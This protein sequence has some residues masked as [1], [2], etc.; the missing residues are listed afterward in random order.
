MLLGAGGLYFAG[1]IDSDGLSAAHIADPQAYDLVVDA[2]TGGQVTPHRT[3]AQPDR[4]DLATADEYGL[5]WPGGT[6]GSPRAGR[7]PGRPRSGRRT[8]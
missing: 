5:S 8:P 1:Q 2:F 4:D 6:G 7:T 3:G